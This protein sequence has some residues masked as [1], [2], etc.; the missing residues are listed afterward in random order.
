MKPQPPWTWIAIFATSDPTSVACSFAIDSA[1]VLTYL[2]DTT[3]PGWLWWGML[4]FV[5]ISLLGAKLAQR[6]VHRLPQKRFRQVVAL[7]LFLTGIYL[8]IT[9]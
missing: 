5:P 2:R 6:I 8:L 3:L 9:A 7:F 1:R 4:A